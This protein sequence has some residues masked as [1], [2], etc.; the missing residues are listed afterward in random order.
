MTYVSLI[1]QQKNLEKVRQDLN[2]L[3]PLS[4]DTI[5]FKR[6]F[7]EFRK[8]LLD[9]E[10]LSP[11]GEYVFENELMD[12]WIEIKQAGSASRYDTERLF[13]GISNVLVKNKLVDLGS[14]R[15]FKVGSK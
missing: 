12:L 14:S 1:R 13:S 9:K 8:C 11:L 4:I 15:I 7:D 6:R 2:S 10:N 5:N 3:D